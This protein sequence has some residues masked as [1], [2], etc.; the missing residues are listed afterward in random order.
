MDL[1]ALARAA[2]SGQPPENDLHRTFGQML[3]QT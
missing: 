1:G 2:I 3:Y